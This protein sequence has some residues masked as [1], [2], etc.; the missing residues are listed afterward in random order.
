MEETPT[1]TDAVIIKNN[2]S[3]YLLATKG[4]RKAKGR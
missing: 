2:R 1:Y 3:P 4:W